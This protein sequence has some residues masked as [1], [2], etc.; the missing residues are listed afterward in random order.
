[1]AESKASN[2][3]PQ[4]HTCTSERGCEV[5]LRTKE[6]VCA[7]TGECG[8]AVKLRINNLLRVYNVR[9]IEKRE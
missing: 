1:M 5:R 4:T 8:Y 3:L 7:Y 6:L 9:I 2:S